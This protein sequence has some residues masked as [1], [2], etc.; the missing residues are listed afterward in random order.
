MMFDSFDSWA[1][2]DGFKV[3]VE[4]QDA[5]WD[6]AYQHARGIIVV[7]IDICTKMHSMSTA[8]AMWDYFRDRY[9]HSSY[10]QTYPASLALYSIHQGEHTIHEFFPLLANTL[11]PEGYYDEA[12]LLDL[13][14]LPLFL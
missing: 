7:T 6:I 3:P 2:I 14:R 12:S 1:Y 5:T 4:K 13:F 11:A 10:A 8:K 9:Q